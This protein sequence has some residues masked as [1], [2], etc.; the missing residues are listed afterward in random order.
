MTSVRSVMSRP[1]AV[2]GTEATVDEAVGLMA[3]GNLRHLPVVHEGRVVGFLSE[4]DLADPRRGAGLAPERAFGH[5]RVRMLMSS[6]PLS[7]E[8]GMALVDA[9]DLMVE[10]QLKAIPVVDAEHRLV[11][12]LSVVEVVR[13]LAK[14]LP[15]VPE[16]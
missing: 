13:E 16:S 14:R 3:K 12:V 10:H 7:V 8:A 4:R 11:G 15:Q 5:L 6:R 2:I 9:I 1:T